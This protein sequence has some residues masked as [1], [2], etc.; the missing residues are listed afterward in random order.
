MH[1]LWAML[2]TFS[3]IIDNSL[4]GAASAGYVRVTVLPSDHFCIHEVEVSGDRTAGS[5]AW[6]GRCC[7]WQV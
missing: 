6:M 3:E 2:A 1:R 7:Q 5:M 4:L